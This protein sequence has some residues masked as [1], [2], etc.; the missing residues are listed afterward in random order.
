MGLFLPQM[1][2]TQGNKEQALKYHKMSKAFQQDILLV[3]NAQV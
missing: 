2:L 3:K 1:F